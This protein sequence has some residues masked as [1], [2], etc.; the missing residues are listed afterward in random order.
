MVAYVS[1]NDPDSGEN[2]VTVCRLNTK[3]FE[4]QPLNNQGQY[5]ASHPP[6]A[7]VLGA[8]VWALWADAG[9]LGLCGH[10][11]WAFVG[12]RWDI[13]AVW[14]D[15]GPLWADAGTVGL[16]GETFG[17]CGQTLGL[18]GFRILV[19]VRSLYHRGANKSLC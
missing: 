18:C 16:C 17:L 19:R 9:T 5:K 7:R 8:D 3:D 6:A 10:R 15:A 11:R 2:G 1:V 4:L 14:A 13:G 12:R